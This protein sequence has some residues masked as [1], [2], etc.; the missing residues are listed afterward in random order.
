MISVFGT[1]GSACTRTVS[2]ECKTA[3]DSASAPGRIKPAALKP[4]SLLQ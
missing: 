2:P 4:E 3:P 1:K